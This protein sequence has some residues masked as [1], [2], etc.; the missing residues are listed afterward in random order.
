MKT[1]TGISGETVK[2]RKLSCTEDGELM[3]GGCSTVQLSQIYGT[4][5]HIVDE[6]GL[7]A[8]AASFLDT[9]RSKYPGKIS[10]HY[11]FK[12]NP[13]PG[14][15]KIIKECGIKAE[16]M[17]GFELMLAL[18]MGYTGEEIVVNG[19]CKT[20]SLIRTC[21]EN[22]VRFI[23]IDSLSELK[24]VSTLCFDLDR[25][26][27]VLL[28]INPDFV[29]SGMNRGSSAAS[30]EGSPFGLDLKGG[31]VT[32]ALEML[33][34][35]KRIR[36]RGFHIHIGSGIRNTNDFTR[37]LSGLK[38]TIS[39]AGKSGFAVD[40]LD[41]GGG[42]GIADSREMTTTELL[43]YQ[44]FDIL[45]SGRISNSKI[46]FSGYAESVTKGVLDLFGKRSVPEL[47]LEPGRC[48]TG[49]NQMLLLRIHQV[50]ERKG[51]K[52]WLIADAGIG[53][54]TMPTYYERHQVLLCNDIRRKASEK[55][56]ITG[57]GCF[58]ADVVYKNILMPRVAEGEIIAILD[59]GAYFTS[60]E[61]SFGFPRPPIVSVSNGMHTLLRERESFRHMTSLDM[62]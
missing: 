24:M 8:G 29:P 44:A 12:C 54:L 55:V 39:D 56:T 38:N 1:N 43:F 7:R 21:L 30:R 31:E 45:P 6:E 25:Y 61:S 14:I 35:M 32:L 15:I 9:I 3:T 57:P 13:V 22:K 53:T 20:E 2:E 52:K 16:V 17:S 26:A 62:F 4:P 51:L 59:S 49:P 18:R 50:K 28:R 36:F 11:A 10:V 40:V 27:D 19:P 58:S 41:I 48:I 33:K 47:I 60:W 42:L 46:T 37:A 23:N 34:V 5:V